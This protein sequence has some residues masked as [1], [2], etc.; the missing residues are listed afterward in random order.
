[1]RGHSGRARGL[2][3][4]HPKALDGTWEPWD[5]MICLYPPGSLL[6]L[7]L[8]L[9]CWIQ[10]SALSIASGQPSLM[11][12]SWGWAPGACW[13]LPAAQHISQ[14]GMSLCKADPAPL[15]LSRKIREQISFSVLHHQAARDSRTQRFKHK[16][17]AYLHV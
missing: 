9:Q 15:S 6:H 8:A 11:P 7:L 13:A 3:S 2:V 10:K 12:D 4:G 14:P 5:K 16:S 17:P 1:M